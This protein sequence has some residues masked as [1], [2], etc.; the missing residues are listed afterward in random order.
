MT[1][2]EGAD[3]TVAGMCS[4]AADVLLAVPGTSIFVAAGDSTMEHYGSIA[5][6]TTTGAT[7]TS[8]VKVD[9]LEELQFTLGIGPGTDAYNHGIPIIQTD[10]AVDAPAR[11]VG[12]TGPAVDAGVRAAFSFPL[13]VGAA[14]IGALTVYRNDPGALDD[15][16][17][18]DAVVLT[19]VITGAI[20]AM[21]AGAADG[22]LGAGMGDG[23]SF[24]SE[25]HQASGIVAVQL[26]IGVGDA[27]V[28]LRAHAFAETKTVSA[29]AAD[30]V[31]RRL[32]FEP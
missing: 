32:Q 11:W 15:D 13:Q 9:V 1:A 24:H 30:V 21:Q 20:L 16:R 12:F 19:G 18:K 27:L 10:L 3:L 2:R 22:L 5:D 17:Y 4:S 31:A 6:S 25:V 28:R 23:G 29:V 8:S 7:Y 26:D 14:R